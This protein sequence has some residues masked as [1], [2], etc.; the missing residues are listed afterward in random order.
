MNWGVH[1]LTV[2]LLG[3]LLLGVYHGFRGGLIRTAFKVIGLIAGIWLARPL[4]SALWPR[5]ED[6]LGF[7]GG[8]YLLVILA[9]VAVA[10]VAG[11]LGWLL[12]LTIRWTPLVWLNHVGGG[13]LGL[14]LGLL[15]AGLI[16]ALFDEL[17][18]MEPMLREAAT[19][20]R[21]FLVLLL[22]I[23]PDLFAEISPLLRAGRLPVPGGAI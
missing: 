9:F 19:W 8:W 3:T 20:E 7:P 23:T 13:L 4:A 11:L 2:A 22:D 5:V 14:F 6:A 15:V 17:A 16:L 21:G 1:L 18:L 12:S 10:L